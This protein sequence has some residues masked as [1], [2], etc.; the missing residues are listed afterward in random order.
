M[1]GFK[2]ELHKISYWMNKNAKDYFR[3]KKQ[4]TFSA[5][6]LSSNCQGSFQFLKLRQYWEK[7][8]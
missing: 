2:N 3:L 1:R 7:Y 4:A 5:V 8:F 6:I